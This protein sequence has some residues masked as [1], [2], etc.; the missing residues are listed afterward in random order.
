MLEIIDELTKELR[1]KRI[2]EDLQR[3]IRLQKSLALARWWRMI[4]EE[5][6]PDKDVD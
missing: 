6:K 3:Q 1:S 2:S 5:S 4:V